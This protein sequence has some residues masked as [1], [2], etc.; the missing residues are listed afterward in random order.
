MAEKIGWYNHAGLSKIVK[1]TFSDLM[2]KPKSEVYLQVSTSGCEC[3]TIAIKNCTETDKKITDSVAHISGSLPGFNAAI[4]PT[5]ANSILISGSG[6]S[7]FNVTFNG[8]GITVN[9][10]D[11]PPSPVATVLQSAGTIPKIGYGVAV[12]RNPVLHGG[13]ASC[14]SVIAN[15]GGD[16]L[17]LPTKHP[18]EQFA[19]ITI[20]NH[21]GK[22]TPPSTDCSPVNCDEGYDCNECIHYLKTCC[23][24]QQVFVQLE[25]LPAGTLTP[26]TM[27]GLPIFYRTKATATAKNGALSILGGGDPDRRVAKNAHTDN[28]WVIKDVIDRSINLYSIGVE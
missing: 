15:S 22:I 7:D 20:E 12:V 17:E 3:V 18:T 25:P 16:I 13:D 9:G 6:N 5:D 21:S 24:D 1:L 14:N 4:D 8:F 11:T 23:H 28:Q 27:I 10:V 19:G 26:S 2:L